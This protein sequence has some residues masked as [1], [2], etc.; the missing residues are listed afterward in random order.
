MEASQIAERLPMFWASDLKDFLAAKGGKAVLF[1][2]TYEALTET[3]RSEGKLYQQDEWVRE[4]VAHLPDVLWVICGREMLRWAELDSDWKDSLSQHIVGGLADEDARQFL[5]SCGIE[6]RTIADT[7]VQ[8][9]TGLPY[10]LDLAVDTYLAA[11]RRGVRPQASDF[12]HAPAEVFTRFLRHL[13]Q[14]EIETLKVL[15]IPRFWDIALF[16]S[17]VTRFN[18]GYPLT[19]F[20]DLCRFSFINT[21]AE[22]EVCTMQQLMRQSLQEHASPELV[23]RVHRV[24]FETYAGRLEG[25][26]VSSITVRQRT[27]LAEA[28]Y[29]GRAVLPAREFFQWFRKPAEQFYRAAQW[30]LLVP[31]YD[32]VERDLEKELGSEHPDVA[33]GLD[34][35]AGVLYKQGKYAES[36]P[37]QRRALATREKVFG[38]EHSDVA[39]SLNNLAAVLNAQGKYA[40][41]E[42]LYRRSLAI[43]GK[44]QGPTHPNT[45]FPLDNLAVTLHSQGKY[46][47][48]EPLYRRSLA[49]REKTLG[50]EHP[51]V[52]KSLNNLAELLYAQ[53]S[54]AEAEPLYRRALAI[55]EKALGPEHPAVARSLDDLAELLLAKGMHTEAEPLARRSLA[56]RESTLGHEH[57]DMARSLTTLAELLQSTGKYAEAETQHRRALAVR[58]KVLGPEH[59][60]VAQSQ[61]KLAELLSAK[62][63]YAEAELLFGRALA[64]EEHVLG[65]DHPDLGKTLKGLADLYAK[66]GRV[67]EAEQ[68]RARMKAI[69]EKHE[70]GRPPPPRC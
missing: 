14:A 57:P 8:G 39:A 22:P 18:T 46:A 40:E 10:Y 31:L 20:S 64:I 48:A 44:T 68:L 29:H 33:D 15:A 32:Q 51:D 3:E 30:Q 50:P 66:T 53:G 62:G 70:N 21:A 67:D 38:P 61:D 55:R 56:I 1:L 54:L 37:L 59:V 58:E 16:E 25:I 35:L 34:A 6:N 65:P 19:A 69:R 42:P 45:A 27:A 49:T 4:L 17:L 41:A 63:E 36:E 52:A 43:V 23:K 7:I 28:F 26:N 47:E 9:S 2:D 12:A 11:G 24:L 13:T 60:A 5:E